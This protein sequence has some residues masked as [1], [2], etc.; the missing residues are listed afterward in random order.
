MNKKDKTKKETDEMNDDIDIFDDFEEDISFSKPAA[1]KE[2][3]SQM[4]RMETI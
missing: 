3:Y 4:I 2:G 1:K